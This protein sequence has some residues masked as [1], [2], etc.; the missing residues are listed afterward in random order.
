VGLYATTPPGKIIN[1]TI[2]VL[3]LDISLEHRGKTEIAAKS[4]LPLNVQIAEAYKGQFDVDVE[5]IFRAKVEPALTVKTTIHG[6][7]TVAGGVG[8]AVAVGTAL[9]PDIALPIVAG[10]GRRLM[11]GIP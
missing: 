1:T 6:G 11:P 7:P 3:D 10:V 9:A 2:P 5:D 4:T 8:V